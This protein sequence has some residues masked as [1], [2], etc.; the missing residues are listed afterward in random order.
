MTIFLVTFHSKLHYIKYTNINQAKRCF[1]LKNELFRQ[2][3]FI[4]KPC[5]LTLI[6]SL[7]L[8]RCN[9]LQKMR[10]SCF[11]WCCHAGSSSIIAFIFMKWIMNWR[12]PRSNLL[13]DNMED[14]QHGRSW[15]ELPLN[16]CYVYPDIINEV[17]ILIKIVEKN[18]MLK[19]DKDVT[20]N[21]HSCTVKIQTQKGK[22]GTVLN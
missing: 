7:M 3:L 14:L 12:V 15:H 1:L 17:V 18:E 10:E 20:K 4:Q 2:F 19:F 16:H 6:S 11:W 9:K 21:Q 13:K 8:T 5:L 22:C